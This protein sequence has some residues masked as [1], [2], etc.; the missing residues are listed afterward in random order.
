MYF[1]KGKIFDP[2][3]SREAI[4]WVFTD[5]YFFGSLKHVFE[6]LSQLN[7]FTTARNKRK[8]LVFNVKIKN[9]F[10]LNLGLF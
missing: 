10:I 8:K 2:R 9:A 3:I 5:I 6:L 4:S 7:T 1:I